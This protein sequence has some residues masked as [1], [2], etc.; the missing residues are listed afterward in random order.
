MGDHRL[1]SMYVFEFLDR[2]FENISASRRFYDFPIP[3]LSAG[4][5]TAAI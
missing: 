3:Q 1:T 2:R 5:P 4:P